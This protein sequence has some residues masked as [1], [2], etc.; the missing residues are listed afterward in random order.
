[1]RIDVPAG[2]ALVFTAADGS[3]LATPTTQPISRVI[4]VDPDR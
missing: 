1:M 4:E 2:T 3:L